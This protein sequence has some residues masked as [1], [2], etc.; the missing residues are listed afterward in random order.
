MHTKTAESNAPPPSQPEKKLAAV[1][2]KPGCCATPRHTWCFLCAAAWTG[3]AT[4]SNA[5]YHIPPS[6]YYDT[7]TILLSN[8]YTSSTP[9]YILAT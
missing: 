9:F 1:L 7:N 3:I 5:P 6:Y 2:L 4:I 8:I